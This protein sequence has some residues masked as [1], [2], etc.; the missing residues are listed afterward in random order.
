MLHFLPYLHRAVSLFVS[1]ESLEG[2]EKKN[3]NGEKVE[4]LHPTTSRATWRGRKPT[5]GEKK[6]KKL[7]FMVFPRGREVGRNEARPLRTTF[8]LW[9]RKWNVSGTMN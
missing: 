4:P 9:G 2:L 3:F 5:A 6:K 8:P 7:I 1:Q